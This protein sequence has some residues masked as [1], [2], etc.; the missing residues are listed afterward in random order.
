M[1]CSSFGIGYQDLMEKTAEMA[2]NANALGAEFVS[3][4]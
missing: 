4:A 1:H 3:V 2:A